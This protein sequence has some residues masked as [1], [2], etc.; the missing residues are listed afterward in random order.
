M[1]P[2]AHPV[3]LGDWLR[4]SIAEAGPM[5]VD[6]FMEACLLHPEFGY[7]RTQTAIG[8]A[9]D[10]I[11][12]PEISQV[13]GELIGVWAAACWQAMGAPERWRLIELGPGRGTL[14]ADLLRALN[15]LPAAR[16]GVE[17]VL[18]EASPVLAA[19]Q[20]AALAG[21]GVPVAWLAKLAVLAPMP[22]VVI[23]NEFLDALPIRQLVAQGG[24]WWERCVGLTKSSAA[25][26]S[27]PHPS[28]RGASARQ[29]VP[30]ATGE[31]TKE[32][33]PLAFM[34]GLPVADVPLQS[35]HPSRDGAI[36][37]IMTGTAALVLDLSAMLA[38]PSSRQGSTRP[39]MALAADSEH[40]ALDGQVKP[41]HDEIGAPLYLLLLDYGHVGP[42]LGDTLQAVRNHRYDHP[43]AHPGAADL[44]AQVDFAQVLAAAG[45][46]GFD[47][48]G[49]ITQA[50][51]LGRLGA[52]ERLQRL[53]RGQDARTLNGLQSGLARI[54]H[55]DGMGARCKAIALASKGLARPPVF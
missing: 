50:E 44:S 31:G 24:H 7:Y 32:P 45:K 41:G 54:M 1:T 21:C 25:H 37:E 15:V 48:Y 12:A 33:S 52:A 2:A 14:M 47:T 17:V 16:A 9:G 22:T 30:L 23:G 42:V 18:V 6:H 19:A 29:A 40:V 43:L 34:C 26:S 49:P 3:S 28:L 53:A 46:A 5:P 38:A 4:R 39:S 8:A 13:F 35:L 55:P 27:T 20:Q 51:F 10:F 11:T 36:L